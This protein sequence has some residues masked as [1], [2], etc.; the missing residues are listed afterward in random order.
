V[1]SPLLYG[2]PHFLGWNQLFPTP[3]ERQIWRISTCVVTGSGIFFHIHPAHIIHLRRYGPFKCNRV[4]FDIHCVYGGVG[5]SPRRKPSTALL[6]RSCSVPARTLVKLLATLFIDKQP[7]CRR[8]SA[9]ES[10]CKFTS[11][12]P[13]SIQGFIAIALYSLDAPCG[14]CGHSFRRAHF[15][16]SSKMPGFE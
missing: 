5:F 7:V 10:L 6:P 2:A 8:E 13:N 1:I 16:A 3:L 9:S 12:E 4:Y 14:V 11:L 15:S